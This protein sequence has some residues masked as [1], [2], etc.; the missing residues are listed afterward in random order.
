K[1]DSSKGGPAQGKITPEQSRKQQGSEKEQGQGRR[2][3]FGEEA[4]KPTGKG[5]VDDRGINPVTGSPR[6]R[7]PSSRHRLP[8]F[9]LL[10]A[11]RRDCRG[12]GGGSRHGQAGLV[13]LGSQHLGHLRVELEGPVEVDAGAFVIFETFAEVPAENVSTGIVGVETNGLFG[14]LQSGS[15]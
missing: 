10:L 7:I 12:S 11:A 5:P 8:E 1:D 6:G 14:V 13:S 15:Q 3:T 2:H 9:G 4:I